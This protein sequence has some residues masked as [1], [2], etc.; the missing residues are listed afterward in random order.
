MGTCSCCG[1]K[2]DHRV[3]VSR[4]GLSHESKPVCYECKGD[5]VDIKSALTESMH[6]ICQSL[7][8]HALKDMEPRMKPIM[9]AVPNVGWILMG[10]VPDVKAIDKGEPAP[11]VAQAIEAYARGILGIEADEEPLEVNNG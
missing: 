11:H 2:A 8:K 6:P 10:F 7:V 3:S 9:V 4:L 1:A 5:I